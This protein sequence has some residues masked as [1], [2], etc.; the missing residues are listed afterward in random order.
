MMFPVRHQN[1]EN[2]YGLII[3]GVEV[4]VALKEEGTGILMSLSD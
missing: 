1:N 4:R 3:I 2:P